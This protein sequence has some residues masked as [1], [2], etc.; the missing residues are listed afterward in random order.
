MIDDGKREPNMTRD[1]LLCRLLLFY[2]VRLPNHPGKWRIHQWIRDR[3]GSALDEDFEVERGGLHWRLNPADFP[4]ASLF[5]LGRLDYWDV[6]HLRRRVA[7]G[8]VVFDVGANFGY[9][10]LTLAR[11]LN[12]QCRVYSFE[13]EPANFARLTYHVEANGMSGVVLP[14]R[15]GL[16]DQ[17]GFA[18]LSQRPGNSGSANLDLTDDPAGV[19]LTTLDDFVASERL[20]RLDLMKVDVEGF[21]ERVIRGGRETLARFHPLIFIELEPARLALKGS[22]VP[23][24]VDLLTQ[25]GYRLFVSR[26]HRLE[27]LR[28]LPLRHG[29]QVNAFAMFS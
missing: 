29:D 7:P 24:V 4:H 14:K 25:A 19:S 3:L 2:G 21:E 10:G 16:A 18:T 5:W 1:S 11:H 27:P 13:P 23:A 12:K 15:L 17:A 22:S 8:S 9:Y 20:D 28:E 26:R 6:E